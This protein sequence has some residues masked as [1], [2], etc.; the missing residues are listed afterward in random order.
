MATDTYS[1]IEDKLNRLEPFDNKNSMSGEWQGDSFVV[2]SYRTVIAWKNRDGS[3]HLNTDKYSVTTSRQQSLVRRV[4][5][6]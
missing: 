3:L 1:T 5:G 2:Y 6:C 4:W